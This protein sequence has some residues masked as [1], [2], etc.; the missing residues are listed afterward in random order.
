[1]CACARVRALMS[2]FVAHLGRVAR[3]ILLK[4]LDT[5][6]DQRCPAQERIVL[7]KALKDVPTWQDA[8]LYV[9]GTWLQLQTCAAC[10]FSHTHRSGSV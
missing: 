9:A 10:E 6:V 4:G 7:S 2:V 5:R 3:E 8:Q 1:M